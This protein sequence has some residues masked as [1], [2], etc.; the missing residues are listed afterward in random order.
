MIATIS[1]CVAAIAALAAIWYARLTVQEAR[2]ERRAAEQDRLRHRLERI[3]ALVEKIDTEYG[4]TGDTWLLENLPAHNMLV[5][6][7]VGLHGLL[8]KCAAILGY[9]GPFITMP[10]VIDEARTEIAFVLERLEAES[11]AARH[12]ARFPFRMPW[13]LS[14][15]RQLRSDTLHPWVSLPRV[16]ALDEPFP[17]ERP[18]KA[19]PGYVRRGSQ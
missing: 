16:T 12:Q 2:T 19:S 11:R 1:A 3:G 7:M 14:P 17:H 5:E 18:I 6:A 4:H 10:T 13:R 15:K 8:P 9:K